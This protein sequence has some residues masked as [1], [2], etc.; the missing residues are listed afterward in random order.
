MRFKNDQP[1]KGRLSQAG[2]VCTA[3]SYIVEGNG[4]GAPQCLVDG[5]PRTYWHTNYGGGQGPVEMPHWALIDCQRALTFRCFSYAPR[6]DG[7]TNGNIGRFELYAGQTADECDRGAPV[8]QGTFQ[9]DGASPY[10]V[11]LAQPVSARFLKLVALSAA[12]GQQF[13]GGSDF[14]L[15]SENNYPTVDVPC[16]A[17]ECTG[18]THTDVLDRDTKAVVGVELEFA[19]KPYAVAGKS[20]ALSAKYVMR[21]GCRFMHKRVGY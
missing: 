9:N 19:F 1:A 12:N 10:F 21:D 4:C 18:A 11:N 20:V 2:W 17:L 6:A 3:D 16:S 15:Y 14:A 13:A 7:G 5:D 8:A